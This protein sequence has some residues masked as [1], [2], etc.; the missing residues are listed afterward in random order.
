MSS[1]PKSRWA[2]TEEDAELE[3]KLKREKE[4]KRRKKAEKAQKLEEEEERRKKAAA[5]AA[6][7]QTN[8]ESAI[9]DDDDDDDDP[10]RPSK[11]RKLTPEPPS[12]ATPAPKLL[13]FD[14]KT[15]T[16]SRSVDSYDKLNDIEEGTYGWV[17]RATELATGRVVALKRL[18]LEAADPNGLPVTGL[19]EIQILKRCR[20]RNVVSMEE[21]VVGNDVSKPDK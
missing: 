5:L 1:K 20:H 19:R 6:T 4:E 13:R 2:S 17:A 9:D 8:N 15:W 21:V 11:R 10:S 14:P 18:K 16:P 7:S 12:A 3:A